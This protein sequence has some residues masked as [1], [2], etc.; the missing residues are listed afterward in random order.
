[1]QSVAPISILVAIFVA[2]E[3]LEQSLAIIP[4]TIAFLVPVYFD[5]WHYSSTDYYLRF[6]K[7]ATG[8]FNKQQYIDTFGGNVKRNYNIAEFVASSTKENDKVFIWGDSSAIYALSNR[9][10]PIKYV[11]DYH[12]RDFSNHDEVINGLEESM[13]KMIVILP[14]SS[15]FPKL[16]KLISRNYGLT[17]EIEGATVWILLSDNVRSLLSY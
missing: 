5:F 7:L 3:D 2:K 6:F 9:L 1:L 11:A 10:P 16:D 8:D 4:L 15:S 14:D 12:I 13:P 17:E